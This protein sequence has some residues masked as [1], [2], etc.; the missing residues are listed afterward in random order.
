MIPKHQSPS[1]NQYKATANIPMKKQTSKIPMKTPHSFQL[2]HFALACALAASLIPATLQA[3]VI[4]WNGGGDGNWSNAANWAGGVISGTTGGL[5]NQDIATFNNNV[6]TTITV[7]TNRNVKT[8][9]FETAAGS[10][11]IGSAGANGGPSLLLSSAGSVTLPSGAPVLTGS[12][13][14]ETINA[15]LVLEPLTNATAGT[16]AF[17]NSAGTSSTNVLKIAGNVSGGTTSAG[18]TLTLNGSSTNA[19]NEISGV[20]SNGGAV[21]GLFMTKTNSGSWNISGTNNSFTGGIQVAGSI[22][23]VATISNLGANSSIGAGGGIFLSGFGN[24]NPTSLKITGAG[25]TTDRNITI[26]QGVSTAGANVA[27]LDSSGSGPVII[28]GNVT[29]SLTSS[30]S[31]ANLFG[32]AGTNTGSNEVSGLMADGDATHILAVTKSG[33]GTWKLSGANTYTGATT[34]SAGALILTNTNAIASSALSMTAGSTLNLRSNASATFNDAGTSLASA[35][36][37]VDNN[38][39]GSGNTLSIGAVS[40]TNSTITVSGNTNN[41]TLGLGAVTQSVAGTTTF[42]VA[43][44]GTTPTQSLILASFTSAASATASKLSFTGTGNETI[45]GNIIQGGGGNVLSLDRSNAAGTLILQGTSNITGAVSITTGTIQTGVATNAFGSTSGIS[46]GA[47]GAL[48]LRGDSSAGFSNGATNYPITVTSSGATI[49]VDQASNAAAGTALSLG[50]VSI[51]GAYT[52]NTTGFNGVSLVL[53]AVSGSTA[54][55]KIVTNNITSPGSLTMAS[56]AES[57]ASARKIT[58][59]GTG[60][61]IVTGAISQSGTFKLAV[62]QNGTGLT[63]LQGTNSYTGVTA[64]S[65]GTLQFAKEVSLYNSGTS[66]WTVGNLPVSSGATAAFNVGGTGEFTS[67]DI[68]KLKSLGSGGGGFQS[69]SFLG[70]DTTNASG[71]NFIYGSNISNP[72][73]GAF[74]LGLTKLGTNMLTLTGSNSYTGATSIKGGTLLVSGTLSGTTAVTVDSGATLKVN[75][76]INTAAAPSTINGTLMG[77]GTMGSVT[78]ASGNLAPGNSIGTL[79]VSGSLT[80]QST[81]T[82]TMEI[83]NTGGALSADLANVTGVIAYG[84]TLT[85]TLLAGSDSLVNGNTFNLFDASSFTG[86]FS[87][88]NLPTLDSGLSWSTSNLPVDGTLMVVPEPGTWA[89]VLGGLGM[90]VSMQRMGRRRA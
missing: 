77:G 44:N 50:T 6:N 36:L 23:T 72:A 53:G 52:L 7:D 49:S 13:L 33:A 62:T 11:I 27:N 55:D 5:T 46:I 45:T 51:P 10:F 14:T 38:G 48:S 26:N 63:V 57:D 81:A 32:L 68:D 89:M 42:S 67:S 56:Y 79:S 69:G 70:L 60:S 28:T 61:T 83:N 40:I 59:N 35:T 21:G 90:L 65:A 82:A 18:I 22:L 4:T 87:A 80:L 15:P 39:S 43:T 8:L 41:Y 31:T 12:N 17:I 34:I 29:A 78:V 71:G 75:G 16:Y 84:G 66:S 1:T 24:T 37:N 58:F 3:A 76:F 74:V 47:A 19:G 88:F 20:I 9:S 86:S 25:G 64:I 54:A 85:V 73:A 30:G 2:R